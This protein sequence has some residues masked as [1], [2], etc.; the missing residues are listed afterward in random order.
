MEGH[1]AVDGFY[2]CV[3]SLSTVGYGDEGF[4]TQNGRIFA[5]FWLIVGTT[6][7]ARMVSAVIDR[8]AQ[9]VAKA[10]SAK[11]A[12]RLL[13]RQADLSKLDSQKKGKVTR[14]DFLVYELVALGRCDQWH[15]DEIMARFEAMDEDQS[16][17][18]DYADFKR[19]QEKQIEA[20]RKRLMKEPLSPLSPP[21][22]GMELS[23][24]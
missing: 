18:L 8:K 11:K 13:L 7:M 3:A 9:E 15:I 5:I 14:F 4:K 24:L 16:G 6:A 20:L 19:A 1:S 10:A 22:S 17:E 12:K 23:P 2:F 21:D